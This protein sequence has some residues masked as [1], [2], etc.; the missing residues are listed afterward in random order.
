MDERVHPPAKNAKAPETGGGVVVR[1]VTYSIGTGLFVGGVALLALIAREN[2]LTPRFLR[3]V[4]VFSC[5]GL[6]GGFVAFVA[7]S[8]LAGRKRPIKRFAAL[9][10]ALPAA[11]LCGIELCYLLDFTGFLSGFEDAP[12]SRGWFI[13]VAFAGATTLYTLFVS[14]L[15]LIMPW[16]LP[17]LFLAAW[18]FARR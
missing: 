12:L 16:S 10:A 7:A 6:I 9:L 14:G 5:G 2:A 11:T 3:L 18:R 13:A 4:I 15:P 8:L 1:A 17:A